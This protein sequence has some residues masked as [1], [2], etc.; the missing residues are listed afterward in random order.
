[1]NEECNEF[2]I[3]SLEVFAIKKWQNL[4]KLK[5]NKIK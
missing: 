3:D 2:Y 5:K 1:M 4:N